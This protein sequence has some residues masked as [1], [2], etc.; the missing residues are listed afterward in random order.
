[1]NSVFTQLLQRYPD[2]QCCKDDIES[3]FELLKKVFQQE[4]KALFCGNGGSAADAEHIVG[5]LM[6]GF[7]LPRPIPSQQ[8]Q[9][10]CELSGEDL[11]SVLQGALPA[12]ALTGQIALSTAVANDN[13]GDMGFAQQVYGL[14]RP[15][16]VLVGISTSG[17]SKN[18][19]NA[20]HVAR[21]N[22]VKTI[23][24]TGQGGGVLAKI[25]DV[26]IRVPA[27]TVVEIQELHLPV[28]HALCASLETEFF[29]AAE[30]ATP[31]VT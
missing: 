18:V 14:A 10:L 20:F 11:G 29:G 8:R 3:A 1:M 28:Y 25:A 2:L 30:K 31:S 6:K 5:E 27:L 19:V 23:A 4:G 21:L 7:L 16:D 9:R 24:L 15:G 26:C 17:N 12:I 22:E 13:R